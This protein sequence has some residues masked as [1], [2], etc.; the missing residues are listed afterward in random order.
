MSQ[1]VFTRK[2]VFDWLTAVAIAAIAISLTVAFHEGIHAITCVTVGGNLQEYSALYATCNS[3]TVLQ[4]KLVAGS[5]PTYNLIAGFLSWVV[6]RTSRRQ[7]SETILFLW[8]F[9][10]MNWFW[11][12]GYFIFSGIA[13]VGDWAVAINGWEPSWLW[14]VLMT[15]VGTILYIFFIRIGLKEFG[16][17]FGGNA[18]EQIHRTNKFF[19][20]TYTTSFVVILIA[21][22][23]CP[24]GFVSPPVT[25]GLLAVA[26]ALSPFL[27]MIR[28]FRTNHFVKLN[29]APLEVHRKW[30]WITTAIIVVFIYVYVLGQTL[31][32]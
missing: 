1:D 18:D 28:W 32:F 25:A 27:L 12:A 21:G 20:L 31:Y 30:R 7:S 19:I 14:R 5:A 16:K 11:G 8:L 6:I 10:L 9:M 23:F 3:S 4:A 2:P 22:F 29:N 13:N 24:F 17:I 15:I 26:G